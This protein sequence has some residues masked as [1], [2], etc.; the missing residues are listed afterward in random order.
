MLCVIVRKSCRSQ[1]PTSLSDARSAA[2]MRQQMYRVLG[3]E[4][5]VEH[6]VDGR[7]G[8]TREEPVDSVQVERLTYGDLRDY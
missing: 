6:A 8:Q 2:E 1:W 3:A 5:L 7:T 4:F